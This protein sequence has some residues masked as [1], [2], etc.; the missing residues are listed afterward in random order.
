MGMYV[1]EALHLGTRMVRRV[2]LK[3]TLENI[4]I[5]THRHNH[6]WIVSELL[7]LLLHCILAVR[8][9]ADV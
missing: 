7:L 9:A 2:V 4:A 3:S 5:D 1:A 8:R 6:T